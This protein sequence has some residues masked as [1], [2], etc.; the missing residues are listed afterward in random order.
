VFEADEFFG[1]HAQLVADFLVGHAL[2]EHREDE[3]A[4]AS[5]AVFASGP[6]VA[7]GAGHG[8]FGV[9]VDDYDGEEAPGAVSEVLE[10]LHAGVSVEAVYNH[11]GRFFAF[12]VFHDDYGL[13]DAVHSHG[14]AEQPH[15]VG[16]YGIGVPA[17]CPDA[18]NGDPLDVAYRVLA[19]VVG[20]EGHDVDSLTSLLKA[21]MRALVSAP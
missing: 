15:L 12:V 2:F 7:D 4:H 14:V 19:G 18:V 9:L 13:G 8:F 16:G 17:V 21:W 20:L 11:V 3:G 1:F 5:D 6:V 10:A